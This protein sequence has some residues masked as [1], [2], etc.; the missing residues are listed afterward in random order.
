MVRTHPNQSGGSKSKQKNAWFLFIIL[1]AV[2]MSWHL[3]GYF[4]DEIAL[5][6][7]QLLGRAAK[8]STYYEKA[9]EEMIDITPLLLPINH[10]SKDDKT[11]NQTEFSCAPWIPTEKRKIV[12][13]S[14]LKRF[15]TWE[16]HLKGVIKGGE[17]YWS[18]CIDY[19]LREFGFEVTVL[20]YSLDPAGETMQRLD[21]GEIYRIVTDSS[22]GGNFQATTVSIWDMPKLLCKVRMMIWWPSPKRK[23]NE[24][25]VLPMRYDEISS[26]SAHFVPFFPHQAVTDPPIKQMIPRSRRAIFI[27]IKT[28]QQLVPE[29]L[30]ALYE[31]G[32]ELHLQCETQEALNP[33]RH[34]ILNEIYGNF[35]FHPKY[36]T[37][38]E[39]S[40]EILQKVAS[41]IG[42]GGPVDSPTPIEALYN[43]AAFLNPFLDRTLNGIRRNS[44]HHALVK[45]GPPYVY[46]YNASFFEAFDKNHLDTLIRSILEAAE[47]A[48]STPFISYT[49]ADYRVDAVKAHVCSNIIDY[50]PCHTPEANV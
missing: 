17:S 1:Y 30:I 23:K 25:S 36:A 11:T 37:P 12:M 48:S 44:M 49:P 5:L 18:A 9:Q 38:K 14:F 40:Q 7:S 26:T 27:F 29:V 46:N 21:R 35:T 15:V 20:K 33:G 10:T 28:C 16:D 24:F 39:F 6:Q 47:T 50:D 34:P 42:F 32:F 13:V 41:V 4:E 2:G 43:G 22:S 3:I 31:A 19:I 45:I 8:T